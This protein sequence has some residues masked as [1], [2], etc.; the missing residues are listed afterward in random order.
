MIRITTHIFGEKR[1][2]REVNQWKSKRLQSIFSDLCRVP[3]RC[4]ST[5]FLTNANFSKPLI[6][7]HCNTA[8]VITKTSMKR[9]N[10]T[11][12]KI[13]DNHIWNWGLPNIYL[14][15]FSYWG[16]YLKDYM[17]QLPLQLEEVNDMLASRKFFKGGCLSSGTFHCLSPLCL[18]SA[19]N[20]NLMAGTVR[21]I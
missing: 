14:S 10:N 21:L 16:Q 11:F 4:S 9:C 1:K 15:L 2:L 7:C 6:S 19:S 13:W 8:V 3:K 5:S 20:P 18:L 17:V 12:I